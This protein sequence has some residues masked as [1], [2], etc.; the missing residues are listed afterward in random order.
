MHNFIHNLIDLKVSMAG[1]VFAL[2]TFSNLELSIKITG[3]I[4]FVG[5]TIRRWYLMEKKNKNKNKE[6]EL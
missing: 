1:L 6:D 4:I 2:I 5:Y 3:S